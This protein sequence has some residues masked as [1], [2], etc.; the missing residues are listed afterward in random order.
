MLT[1]D[2]AKQIWR[3]DPETGHF[4]WLINP[5]SHRAKAGDR[6]GFVHGEAGKQYWSLHYNGKSYHAS[7]VA[8]LM[9]TGEWP[10]NQMDHIDRNRLDDR[11]C[12]LREASVVEN[13]YNRKRKKPNKLGVK[14]VHVDDRCK[15]S[16]IAVIGVNGK[17][18]RLGVF[19]TIEE[20]KAVY[21]AAVR[22]YH[23]EF[24]SM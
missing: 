9:M 15:S 3:Y 2:Q 14:G 11:W 5:K 8:C 1:A 23:G 24:A 18:I 16:F 22:K 7:R 20:A 13:C 6:A 12:N 17:R 4:F 19:K 21:D 10:K